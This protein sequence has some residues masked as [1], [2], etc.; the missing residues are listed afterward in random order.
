MSVGVCTSNIANQNTS[1]FTPSFF[2]DSAKVLGLFILYIHCIAIV[3]LLKR[4]PPQYILRMK[5]AYW[6]LVVRCAI[7]YSGWE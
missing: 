3:Y 6:P 2:Q 7:L 1:E 4:W 5:D